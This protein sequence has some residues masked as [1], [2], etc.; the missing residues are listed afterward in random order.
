MGVY[1][2]TGDDGTTGL[3]GGIRV[4]KGDEQVEAYGSVDELTSFL[5]IAI[6]RI[7][8]KD[9]GGLLTLIQKNLYRIMA[10]LSGAKTNLDNL[11]DETKEIEKVIDEIETNLPKLTRFILPQG[12]EMSSWFHVIRT[13]CRRAERQVVGYFKTLESDSRSLIIVQ[14][15]NR[16][17][18]LFFVM[19]RKY[20]KKEEIMS[21]V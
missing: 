3:F 1:T 16:L 2:K 13:V 12:G 17:S 8:N 18:D 9:E 4:S 14:Y 19:A 10:S 21:L 11:G 7:L 5:G 15:L 20:N 6:D